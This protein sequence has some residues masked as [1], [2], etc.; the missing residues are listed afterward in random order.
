MPD[1][2]E[3]LKFATALAQLAT[4]LRTLFAGSKTS[5]TPI[6]RQ[7]DRRPERASAKPAKRG[8]RSRR[9]VPRSPRR[10]ARR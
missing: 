4:A 5:A 6:A 8:R 7:P 1:P 9:Q 10:G 3:I 2:T